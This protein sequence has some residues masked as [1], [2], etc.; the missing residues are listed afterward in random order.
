[1]YRRYK[2]GTF[3]ETYGK[4]MATV[5]IDGDKERN[6]WLS[7]IA[8]MPVSK[9]TADNVVRSRADYQELIQEIE[10]LAG[11]LDRLQVKVK[12]FHK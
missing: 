11:A 7:S 12:S 3:K 5:E 9:K 4:K 2:T 10:A 1:M 6:I 8:P